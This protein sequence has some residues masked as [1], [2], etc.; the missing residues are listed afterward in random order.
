MS[1]CLSSL[2]TCLPHVTLGKMKEVMLLIRF[3][4]QYDPFPK[5]LL[6]V[7]KISQ[8]CYHLITKQVK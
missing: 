3:L 2:I 4:G 1:V 5:H 8:K 6:H 7:P